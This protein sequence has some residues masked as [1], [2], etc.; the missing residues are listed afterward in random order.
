MITYYRLDGGH[1]Q[2]QVASGLDAVPSQVLWIDL[3]HPSR[4]EEHFVETALQVDIPTREEMA[5]I[6]DS[7][8]FYEENGV[9]YL[10]PSVVCGIGTQ[11]P[12]AT[13]VF[14]IFNGKCLITVHYLDLSSLHGFPARLARQPEKHRACDMIL[15]SLVDC[16]VDRIA[17]T[18]EDLQEQ[19]DSLTQQVF[20]ERIEAQ[21]PEKASLQQVVK[22]LGLHHL[23][24]SKL[25][26]SL[27]SLS[28]MMIYLRQSPKDWLGGAAR[29]WLKAIE[30]DIRS[31]GEYQARM[32]GKITFL[33]DATLGLINIEQN[34]IIKVLS[35]AAVLFLPPTLVGTIYGMNFKDMPELEWHMGYPMALGMMAVS[36][37]LSYLLF[38]YK[39]WL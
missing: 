3:L 28:R 15:A 27:M 16:F 24:L 29:N 35:I 32:S 5:E 33:L 9:L 2:Q 37:W 1:L 17:D 11:R 38:K 19:L 10:T 18:L 7:S 30:R 14:F 25:G 39:D 13:D 34:S 6:E 26:D 36:A 4:E 31:L 8:R 22:Q 21:S 12:E 20:A 23:L